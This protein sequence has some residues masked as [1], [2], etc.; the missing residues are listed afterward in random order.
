MSSNSTICWVCNSSHIRL[1]RNGNASRLLN[2]ELFRITAS[3]YGVTGD[4]YK[5]DNCGF[6]FCPNVNNVLVQYE[7]MNDEVYEL[8]RD[9]RALQAKKIL[10]AISIYK[11][12]GELLD[13]GA[14]SG[15]LVEQALNQSF[16][17][18]GIEPSLALSETAQTL[19]LPVRTGVLP[20]ADFQHRFD[21]V[22]LID[23]IEHVD[24]PRILLAEARACM[25]DTGI[26]VIV[27][28]DVGSL[29]ASIMRKRW[30]HYRLAHIG[31]FNQNTLNRLLDSTGLELIDSFR[32]AW[33]FPASYLAERIM[34]YLPRALRFK[35]PS[36]PHG[37]TVR[38]NLFDSLLIIAR[39]KAPRQHNE[40]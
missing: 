38:L 30:W 22:S 28:P 9:Q 4:I 40:T 3:D 14:G 18:I 12:T 1:Q 24:S 23:V 34:Q 37:I 13:V 10:N 15:I 35:L 39:K 36:A 6:L 19:G 26:C 5:C 21:V 25:K 29:A 7:Q 20:Q 2:P 16:K 11:P 32:P 17:A 27:T 31:Y 33:Y 8:T